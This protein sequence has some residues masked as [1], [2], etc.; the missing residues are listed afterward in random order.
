[1]PTA[2]SINDEKL[3]DELGRVWQ[4]YVLWREKIFAGYL[5]V[6]AALGYALSKVEGHPGRAAA[7]FALA[8][9]VS[10]VFLDSGLP[11]D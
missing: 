6:L 5:S 3:Y 4:Q 11:N 2:M 10:V 9:V 8:D 7:V 1:M